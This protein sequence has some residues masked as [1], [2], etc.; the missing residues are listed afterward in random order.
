M[1]K[2]EYKTRETAGELIRVDI[3]LEWV[4]DFSINS[5]DRNFQATDRNNKPL[6]TENPVAFLFDK[7]SL[8]GQ[9]V[10]HH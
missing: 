5:E 4:A 10:D 8:R 1:T 3:D 2:K 6:R 7:G 9:N